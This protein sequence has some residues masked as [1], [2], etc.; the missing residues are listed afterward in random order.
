[1]LVE[2]EMVLLKKKRLAFLYS[3]PAYEPTLKLLGYDDLGK[4]LRDLLSSGRT[5]GLH[6]R[7]PDELFRQVVIEST[8]GELGETVLE[9]FGGLVEGITLRPPDQSQFDQQFLASASLIKESA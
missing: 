3:T 4:T 9:W 1:M 7:I 8:W 5:V 6:E 2:K